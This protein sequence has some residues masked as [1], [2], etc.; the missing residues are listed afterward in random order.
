M[1]NRNL[2]NYIKMATALVASAGRA[3]LGK[4]VGSAVNYAENNS[5]DLLQKA[6]PLAKTYGRKA[7][8]AI[9]RGRDINKIHKANRRFCNM[10]KKE[11]R[12]KGGYLSREPL[13]LRQC[14]L[15][16]GRC[17]Q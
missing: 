11:Y 1:V 4:A 3:L 17:Y 13:C 15:E 9:G 7:V 10:T 12:D 2:R 14:F 16:M 6:I 5:Q 8:K